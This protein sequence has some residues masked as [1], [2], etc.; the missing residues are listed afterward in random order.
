MA[1]TDWPRSERP[2]EKLLQRGASSLSDAE[3][4]AIFVRCGVPG[5]SAVDVSR[6]ALSQAGGLRSLLNLSPQDLGGYRGI[7]IAKHVEFQ[8]AL[9]LGRRYVSEQLQRGSALESPLQTRQLLA[10]QLRTGPTRYFVLCSL[11]TSTGCF[12]SQNCSGG[13]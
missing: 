11:T 8:A 10:L 1:I 3:L 12:I 4:L 6:D 5:K 9:E 7:G 2:R 13:R